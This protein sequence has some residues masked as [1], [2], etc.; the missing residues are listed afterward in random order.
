MKILGIVGS[1]K[2]SSYNKRIMEYLVDTF[3][4]DH[5]IKLGEI[6]DLPLYNEDIENE[7][8]EAVEKLREDIRWA[9]GVIIITP[10]HNGSI[11][12]ALKNTL[13]W[14]SRVDRVFI[15]KP[16]MILSSSISTL[17]GVKAQ[18]HLRDIL[19]GMGLSTYIEPGVE[20]VIGS[21]KDKLDQDGKL[22]D[23]PTKDHLNVRFENFIGWIEKIS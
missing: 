21:V 9:D 5:T 18:S 3:S 14:M 7:K 20:T 15:N 1:L 22:I 13:D 2:A 16:V 8:I 11:S 6:K 4:N 12:A 23:E 17:G 19:N 10:E